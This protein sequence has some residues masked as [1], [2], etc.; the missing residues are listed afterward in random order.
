MVEGNLARVTPREMAQAAD[1]GDE[2]VR[3]EIIRAAEYI[4]IGLANTVVILH[5]DIIVLGGSVAK[6][7]PLLFDTVRQTV[8]ERTGMFPSDNVQIVESVLDVRAGL[9][10]G[11]ALA[12]SQG[13]L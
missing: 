9:L 13:V 12:M 5:P 2:A 8:Q 6:L 7:G 3:E 11:I 1:A 4:G 10:G